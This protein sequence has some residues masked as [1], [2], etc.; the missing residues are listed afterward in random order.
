MSP[1]VVRGRQIG[2]VAGLTVVR[3]LDYPYAQ[4]CMSLIV[5]VTWGDR[6]LI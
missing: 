1:C 2:D 5:G 6:Y 3:V 4:A